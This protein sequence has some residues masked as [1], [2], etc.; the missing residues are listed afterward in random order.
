MDFRGNSKKSAPTTLKKNT[1]KNKTKKNKQTQNKNTRRKTKE[2][3]HQTKQAENCES[4][5]WH[6]QVRVF[7]L[8]FCWGS[9]LVCAFRLGAYVCTWANIQGLE[10]RV[11]RVQGLGFQGLGFRVESIGRANELLGFRV[12]GLGLLGFLGFRVFRVFKV[13][14]LG[15]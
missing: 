3:Q 5:Y 8:G 2:K 10:F 12:Q 6:T 13:Q 1:K 15:A 14:G 7:C 9:A 4:A 11:F